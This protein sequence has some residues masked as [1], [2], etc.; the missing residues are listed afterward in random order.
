M[1]KTLLNVSSKKRSSIQLKE[2]QQKALIA[3]EG[4]MKLENKGWRT[5]KTYLSLFRRFLAHFPNTEP[6]SIT[7]EQIEQ[8]IIFKKQDNISDSQLNQLLNTLNCFYIRLLDQ[9]EKVVQL[10]RPKKKRKLPNVY[11]VEELQLLLKAS[12]NLKHKC[13]LLLIYSGG[14]RRSEL[15][16]LKVE[17]IN[18]H[19]NTIFVRNGKG[20]KDRYTLFSEK[21][22]KHVKEY[23]AQ[24]RP[25]YYLF[26]GQHGGRYSESSIQKVFDNARKKSRVPSNV[27]IHGLRHSFTSHMMEKGVPLKAIQDLLGHASIKT[28]EGYLHLSNKFRREIRSPLDDLDI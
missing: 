17:D 28:T 14:L 9:K 19:R 3:L 11:A 8:Y 26:E 7:K 12:D 25:R 27:T 18:F 23:I 16:D 10:E 21:A 1:S 5:Q 2:V 6:S 15:L 24:Y 22:Q 20:G 4:K 13:M